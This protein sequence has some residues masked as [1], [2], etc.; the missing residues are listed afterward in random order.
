MDLGGSESCGEGKAAAVDRTGGII[1]ALA[2][3]L[4]VAVG[5]LMLSSNRL[6]QGFGLATSLAVILDAM[7]VRT[8]VVPAIMALLG[9]WAWRGPKRLQRVK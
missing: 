4:A 5:S 8:Y 1:T 6:L 9:K 7:I 2:L 3:I